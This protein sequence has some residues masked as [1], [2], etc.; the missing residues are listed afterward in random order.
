[1]FNPSDIQ[2]IRSHRKTL[3]LHVS[4]DGTVVVK[5]PLFIFKRDI[6]RFIEQHRDW[7]EQRLITVANHSKRREKKYQHGEVYLY[8]GKSY[9]LDI[10]N[11]QQIAVH[12]DTLRFPK[13][14]GFRIKK[15]LE[16]WYIR[17]A[18][19]VIT[20][21][22]EW[23]AKEMYAEYVNISYSDTSS[24]WGSCTHDNRLQFNW[25]LIMAPILT[26]KYVVIHELV[27]TKEKNHS[28]AF[29]SKVRYM[30]PTYRH[31]RNWLKEHGG[32]LVT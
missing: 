9:T 2:I 10:G 31:Q 30:S 19:K 27:H 8:I 24:K 29:W 32:M 13:A 26:I 15:E 20:Q 17:Q 1:M 14:L 6:T 25:R 23:Y 7:I 5:A 22:V 18:K 3:A 28:A 12:E 4:P 16:T 11:Y 21:Q